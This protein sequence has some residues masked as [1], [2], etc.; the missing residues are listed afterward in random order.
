ML[1]NEEA[2]RIELKEE[3]SQHQWVITQNENLV[4]TMRENDEAASQRESKLKYQLAEAN[5]KVEQANMVNLHE[6]FSTPKQN[7][8]DIPPVLHDV[9]PTL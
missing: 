3:R 6:N 4:A 1:Q 8:F 9:C 2:M 5:Q 7:L